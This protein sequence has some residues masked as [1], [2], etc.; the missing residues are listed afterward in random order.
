[1]S[2]RDD[3]MVIREMEI[4]R[5]VKVARDEAYLARRKEA[6]KRY[7]KSFVGKEKRRISDI[8]ARIKKQLI[9]EYLK[10]HPELKQA[11]IE[12]YFTQRVDGLNYDGRTL[13]T[14][15]SNPKEV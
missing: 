15:E 3:I 13:E 6:C 11:L 8:K 1:M 4:P 10:E 7:R 5:P 12:K 9:Q 14:A 2:I